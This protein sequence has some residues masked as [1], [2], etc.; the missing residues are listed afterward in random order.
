MAGVLTHNQEPVALY[1]T[2]RHFSTLFYL[3]NLTAA[4]IQHGGEIYLTLY[5]TTS[6]DRSTI[7]HTFYTQWSHI[8][9]SQARLNSYHYRLIVSL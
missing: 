1:C 4:V 5:H 8:H 2:L 3:V 6:H 9:Y 7:C